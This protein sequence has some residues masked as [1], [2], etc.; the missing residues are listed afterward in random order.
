MTTLLMAFY[1][2]SQLCFSAVK[3]TASIVPQEK[4]EG[5][6]TMYFL[7]PFSIVHDIFNAIST[8][9]NEIATKCYL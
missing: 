4:Y 6:I 8:C 3:W 9:R 5:A 1:S 2:S 7:P